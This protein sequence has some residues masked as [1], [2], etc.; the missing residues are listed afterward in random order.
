MTPT[1]QTTGYFIEYYIG[2][3]F[4]GYTTQDQPDREKMGWWG[5]RREKL[6]E[7]V[8]TTNGKTIKAGT[9]V[10]TFCFPLCGR[11]QG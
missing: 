1:Y 2:D 4:I 8:T 6:F 7:K 10:K 9:E 5:Q 3:K 11:K